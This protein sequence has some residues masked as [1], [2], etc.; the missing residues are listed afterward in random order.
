[1]QIDWGNTVIYK[2]IAEN[3]YKCKYYNDKCILVKVPPEK[4]YEIYITRMI[5]FI[6]G[7][8]PVK[9]IATNDVNAMIL[10]KINGPRMA[11]FI[12]T[13]KP[14]DYE[15][16]CLYLHFICIDQQLLRTGIT[17]NWKEENIF[18]TKT[19]KQEIRYNINGKFLKVP[20]FGFIPVL[21]NYSKAVL[22]N[23]NN[24]NY[25][26]PWDP[27]DYNCH[28]KNLFK[29]INFVLTC[30]KHIKNPNLR[31]IFLEASRNLSGAAN[32]LK[33]IQF[34]YTKLFRMHVYNNLVYTKPS[35]R[36]GYE[37]TENENF[38]RFFFHFIANSKLFKTI[39]ERLTFEITKYEKDTMCNLFIDFLSHDRLNNNVY[40]NYLF[41]KQPI[42]SKEARLITEMK[43]W[44]TR[45]SA[46]FAQI[47]DTF[48]EQI[49]QSP[50]CD[51]CEPIDIRKNTVDVYSKQFK[52][53]IRINLKDSKEAYNLSD[54]IDINPRFGRFFW[55][56]IAS[57]PALPR[58]K[59]PIL[60]DRIILCNLFTQFIIHDRI[61]GGLYFDRLFRRSEQKGGYALYNKVMK[62]KNGFAHLFEELLEDYVPSPQE[63]LDPRN[64]RYDT[65][66][67]PP[68]FH[69]RDCKPFF[70]KYWI[71][72]FIDNFDI[73]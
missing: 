73:K 62:Y 19:D 14:N 49:Q 3:I 25:T 2:Q 72:L 11:D 68:I 47:Y 69:K 21:T 55:Y 66:K 6:E 53:L 24:F 5:G 52:N 12:E 15:I 67:K 71:N 45:F 36:L 51:V 70:I 37:M 59:I 54:E 58:K 27:P 61:S 65:T 48:Q 40:Y 26:K 13:N 20:V 33:E 43:G 39:D 16:M 46:W 44:E 42:T 60:E 10:E 31:K 30:Y 9:I 35:F 32:H 17:Y 41:N 29:H 50:P 56:F 28:Q 38:P 7:V 8:E 22:I 1:M 63:P 23:L 18:I 64:N 4:P 34:N 57:Q